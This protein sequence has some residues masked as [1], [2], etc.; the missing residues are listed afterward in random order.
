MQ[1]VWK[2]YAMVFFLMILLAVSVSG[3]D[4][5]RPGEF[6]AE[7]LNKRNT[8]AVNGIFV[9]L[10]LLSHYA[11]YADFGGV[12]DVPYLGL[13]EHLNQLVVATFMFYSGYGMTEALR[14]KGNEYVRKIPKKFWQLLLRFD[15]ALVLYLI[16]N[17]VLGIRYPLDQ[18]LLAFTTWTAI[19]NSNWYITAILVLYVILYISF[20]LCLAGGNNVKRR[21]IAVVLTFVLTTGAIYIQIILGRPAY[22]YDTMLLLPLGCLYSEARPKIERFVKRNDGV[23]LLTMSAAAAIYMFTYNHR[24]DYGIIV[25]SIWGVAFISLVLLVTMKITI[26][27]GF[28]EWTGKHVFGIYI[29]QRLPMTVLEQ[30]GLIESHKYMSLT[31]VIIITFAMA[32]YFQKYTDRL[33]KGIEYRLMAAGRN[34]QKQEEA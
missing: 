5:C 24:W 6:N 15:L 18:T 8:A 25:F 27:N 1:L 13:R 30:L 7:Y 23:Y 34:F 11:Q 3:S 29:L 9:I 16:A 4:F 20:G 22:C 17:A 10:V 28:L 14:S 33:L 26:Y 32:E 31:A 2:A 19:G 12:Y 21:Y